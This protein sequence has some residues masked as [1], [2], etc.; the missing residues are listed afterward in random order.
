MMLA[1]YDELTVI[2]ERVNGVQNSSTL[3]VNQK[4]QECGDI[5]WEYLTMA[6]MYGVQYAN[7]CF[8]TD[9]LPD[10]ERLSEVLAQEIAG[11]DVIDRVYECVTGDGIDIERILKIAETEMT[12]DFNTASLD[13][14]E[15]V[16]D[17]GKKVTKKW[18]TMGDERVRDTH[19]FLEGVEVPLNE[20]FYTY[21]GDSAMSPGGFSLAEN[22]CGCRC[23]LG[24][25]V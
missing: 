4:R 13:I 16:A 2:R 6:Y 24:F 7:D 19:D 5:L 18:V 21:D 11:K 23:Y 9:L 8:G 12:R 1:P 25:S 10:G 15:Q 14:A 3:T 22:N 17:S 20:R